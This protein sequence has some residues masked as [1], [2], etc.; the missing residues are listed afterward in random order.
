MLV[1]RTTSFFSHIGSWTLVVSV[2]E[3]IFI[4]FLSRNL[5]DLNCSYDSL[6]T[7]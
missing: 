7:V 6:K 2:K 3:P 1:F 5:I 4:G